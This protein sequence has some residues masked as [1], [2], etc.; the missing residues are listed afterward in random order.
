MLGHRQPP[1]YLWI[2]SQVSRQL[3]RFAVFSFRQ[4]IQSFRPYFPANLQMRA[5]RTLQCYN[6]PEGFAYHQFDADFRAAVAAEEQ[7]F[8]TLGSKRQQQLLKT[9]EMN[10][11][12]DR[13]TSI[14]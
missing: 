6:Q 9:S 8:E 12:F 14:E 11:N 5:A 3:G 7:Y 1:Y 2:P 10:I 4:L 13:I